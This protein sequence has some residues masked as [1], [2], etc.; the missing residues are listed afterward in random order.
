MHLTRP[1]QIL[2]LPVVEIT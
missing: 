2:E 1:N